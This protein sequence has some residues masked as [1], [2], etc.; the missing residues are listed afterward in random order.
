MT[1]TIITLFTILSIFLVSN[2]SAANTPLEKPQLDRDYLS[3]KIEHFKVDRLK[4]HEAVEELASDYHIP[5]GI[6]VNDIIILDERNQ[7]VSVDLSDAT[8]KE[9]L[10]ALLASSPHYKMEVVNNVIN[11]YPSDGKNLLFD[12]ILSTKLDTFV[13]HKSQSRLSV[14]QELLRHPA[15]EHVASQYNVSSLVLDFGCGFQNCYVGGNPEFSVVLRNVTVPEI[16]NYLLAESGMVFWRAFNSGN[17]F[18]I[19]F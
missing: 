2:V 17:Y 14:R 18:T 13:I 3:K 1:R 9:I 16:L 10:D 4:F 6:V 15:V 8:V 12:A 11:L 5:I 7:L 19:V